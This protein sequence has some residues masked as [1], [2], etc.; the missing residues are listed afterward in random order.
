MRPHIGLHLL[1]MLLTLATM[2]V[3]CSRGT[4]SPDAIESLKGPTLS[5]DFG[6]AYWADQA[7]VDSKT[8]HQ[9]VEI[10]RKATHHRQPNCAVVLSSAFI[11]GLEKATDGPFP[12]YGTDSGSSGVPESL[13]DLE[14]SDSEPEDRSSGEADGG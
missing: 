10:C 7:A 13:Q 8:W 3:A 5:S 12:E 11:R 14:G 2:S 1:S 4:R 9:A 6:A